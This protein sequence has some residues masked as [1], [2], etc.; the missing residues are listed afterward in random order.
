MLW[1]PRFFSD[2]S[3]IPIGI[4]TDPAKQLHH[5]DIITIV[6]YYHNNNDYRHYWTF[7]I[8]RNTD[9]DC[10]SDHK[11]QSLRYFSSIGNIVHTSISWWSFYPETAWQSFLLTQ[12]AV[13][14]AIPLKY[15]YKKKKKWG[16]SSHILYMQK[17]SRHIVLL[18][19][20]MSK[21]R[22]T[23]SIVLPEGEVLGE[24]VMEMRSIVDC[25]TS[26]LVQS[27]N[28]IWKKNKYSHHIP[29]TE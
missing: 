28:I 19:K 15:L 1:L 22:W 7:H 17:E 26:W 29:S 18:I 4:L 13:W 9:C 6:R 27:Q 23:R 11:N 16:I 5:H 10:P 21:V 2:T 3:F 24:V 25:Q 14:E 20:P 12:H 8:L